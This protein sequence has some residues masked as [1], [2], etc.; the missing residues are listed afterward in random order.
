[1][2]DRPDIEFPAVVVTVTYPGVA[3]T[4]MESEITR[5]VEDAV[6]TIAGIEQM[7]STVDEGASTTSIEFRFGTDLSAAL[8]DVRDAM[9][10]I[11]SDLPADANE[12]IVS[13]V[14]TAG[15]AIV[16]WS[17]A[18]DNM[19]DTELSW[20]VDLTVTRELSAVPGVGRVTRVGGVA[21]EIRVDLDPDRMAA[22]G[23]TAS[24]V[25][26]QLRRIQAEYP[27]GEGRSAAS[28]RPCARPASSPPSTTCARCRSRCP[29]AATCGSTRSPRCATRPASSARR[30]CSTASPSS[31]FEIVRSWGA[32]ALDV[33]KD[34]RAVVERLQ[35]EYPHVKFAEASSQVGYIQESFD[36]SMEM[37]IEGAILAI[38]V[39]WLFLRDWRATLISAVALPLSIIP[40]FWAIWALGYTLNILTL[41]ALSLVVGIL[42]DDAIVEVENIVRH[43]RMGK[44]PKE[45]AMDA[46]IEIGLAV[47]A[48]TL[49]ICAVFVPVAFM[50]GIAGEFFG[51]FS[52]TVVV[53]VLFSLLVARTLTP[54]M[55]AYFL[56]PH[57]RPGAARR[58]S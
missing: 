12:P 54:M 1:M 34:A 30:R 52:F 3:P 31:A 53:A 23:A 8:D 43:L 55:A 45:A 36:A 49:T 40:T 50:S 24:D 29:T 11:R 51:P 41:L 44:K 22:L 32:S 10:R 16:T 57:D 18:S 14:T 48:T 21:R 38:I 7:T 37:L 15:G 26:R 9:T 39:V 42:V 5:K 20:F 17:V 28:S 6:A 33:A 47:V 25:S 2:L 58:A 35:T 4:Q 27:G 56:K 13:R 46:A 19:T